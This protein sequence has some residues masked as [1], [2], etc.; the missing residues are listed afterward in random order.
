MKEIIF[1]RKN[2]NLEE[3][4]LDTKKVIA[5]GKFNS[6]HLGHKDIFDKVK[7]IARDNNLEI[8]VMLYP[9]HKNDSKEE[10]KNI[11]PYNLR[12][13]LLLQYG[14][15]Y[16]LN[17][18]ESFGNYQT[19]R[20]EFVSFLKQL[21]V[22]EVVLGKNFTFN[23]GKTDDFNLLR[24]NFNLTTVD[25]RRYNNQIISTSLLELL[26][27]D[28]D[29]S[30]FSKLSGY[31]FFYNGKVVYGKRLASK[32]NLPTANIAIDK[33]QLVPR[34]GIYISKIKI[35]NIIY[36]SITSIS[37]NPTFEE[38]KISLETHILNFNQDIYKKKVTVYLL[39]FVR[40]PIKFN[41]VDDLFEKIRD[42]KNKAI[43]YFK[44][45]G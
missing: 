40:E 31:D 27:S 18:E 21:N 32:Y 34:Q 1:S 5:L 8:I 25:L 33:H 20:E 43:E 6:F 44:N 2:V 7:E 4:N 11:I 38:E 35:D 30:N 29:V 14:V 9:D 19:T 3:I 42:D 37:T 45:K 13:K 23:K 39:E 28:G 17:F 41:N 16:I 10:I 12:V 24:N 15:K 26:L 36:P 22:K